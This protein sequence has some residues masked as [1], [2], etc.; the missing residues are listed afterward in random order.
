LQSIHKLR[1][2]GIVAIAGLV[3]AACNAAG[4]S[5]ADGD[6]TIA[7][8]SPTDGAEVSVPFTVELDSNVDLGPPESGNRHAHLYFDTDIT[9]TD[10]DLVY[11]NTF[12]VTRDLQPGPH[13]I[14][15]S[16]RNADHSDAGPSQTFEITVVAGNGSSA[17]P[18]MSQDPNPDSVY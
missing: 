1:I 12:E 5:G 17:P 10:Y 11:G 7:V 2:A 13:T 4:G 9:S 18:S 6:L 14:I 15:A 8:T 16:L 3:L